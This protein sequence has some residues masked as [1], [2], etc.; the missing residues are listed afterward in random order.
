IS[1]NDQQLKE[2]YE[3]NKSQY[4]AEEQRKA[5]HILL[6]LAPKASDK[7][8]SAVNLKAMQISTELNAGADFSAYAKK[9]SIDSGSANNGG[10]IGYVVPG[11][12][13]PKAFVDAVFSLSLNQVSA[14]V[15]SESGI[16]IIKL[17]EVKRPQKSFKQVKSQVEKDY[18]LRQSETTYFKLAEDMVNLSNEQPESLEP[19]AQELG[20]KVNT[21]ALFSR[22]K[23]KGIFADPKVLTA[24]FDKELIQSRYNSDA[25][26]LGAEH[27]LLIRVKDYQ[28][29]VIKPLDKVRASI[30]NKLKRDK[31]IEQVAE[32]SQKLITKLNAGSS[33][34]SI[35]KSLGVKWIEK[36]SVKR[37]DSAQLDSAILSRAFTMPKSDKPVYTNIRLGSGNYAILSVTGVVDGNTPVANIDATKRLYAADGSK[38]YNRYIEHL[39]TQA[40]IAYNYELLK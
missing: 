20:L 28:A 23:A 25:I 1:A 7:D 37:T 18:K 36:Q 8:V 31:A 10:D 27:I 34:K 16:H 6:E 9:H 5:S 35:A 30:V 2:Y 17:T 24:A 19:V 3:T 13:L 29:S 39:K 32:T 33:V 12:G 26:E 11:S 14:P 21:T 38:S 4:V 40:D 22:N 15:R